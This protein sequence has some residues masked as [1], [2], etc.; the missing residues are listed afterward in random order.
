[1]TLLERLQHRIDC[2]HNEITN[3]DFSGM[4]RVR[5]SAYHAGEISEQE[6]LTLADKIGKWLSRHPGVGF[7]VFYLAPEFDNMTDNPEDYEFPNE[8]STRAA[9][10]WRDWAVGIV[11][12][13]QQELEVEEATAAF[14]RA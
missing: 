11:Q 1:M 8:V 3:G 14:L 7:V 6:N 13:A 10:R 4:C 12:Q 5:D 9:D 2:V